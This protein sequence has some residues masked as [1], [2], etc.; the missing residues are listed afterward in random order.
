MAKKTSKQIKK[1]GA[2]AFIAGIVIALI[3]GLLARIV[4]DVVTTSVLIVLGL[5]VG[6]IN[7]TDHEVKDYLVTTVILVL[8]ST[9]GISVLQTV[10]YIG[11]YLASVL[12]GIVTF[13]IPATIVV[14]LKEIFSLAKN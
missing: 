8:V 10:M 3:A 13:V 5:I 9:L 1:L 6:F 14:A 7:V 12:Q 11:P 4:G 2:Y